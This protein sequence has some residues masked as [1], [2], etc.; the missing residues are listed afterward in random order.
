VYYEFLREIKLYELQ[1]RRGSRPT[2]GGG[3]DEP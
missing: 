1:L 2:P 3:C